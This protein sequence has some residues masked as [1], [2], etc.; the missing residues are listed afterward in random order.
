MSKATKWTPAQE[1]AIN[2]KGKTLLISAAA[3]SGK[4]ATLTRRIIKSITDKDS[5]ADISRL[6]VVTFTVAAASELKQRISLALSRE[7]ATDPSN[8]RLS[9]QLVMLESAKISTIDSFAFSVVK[10]NFQ[11]LSLP[12]GFKIG[13]TNELYLLHKEIIENIIEKHYGDVN[14]DADFISFVENFVDIK[15]SVSLSEILLDLYERLSSRAEGIDFALEASKQMLIEADGD[16]F[17]SLQGRIIS[18]HL[19]KMFSYYK[20]CFEKS[21]TFVE[22]IPEVLSVYGPKISRDIAFINDM[23]SALA[24]GCYESA[25]SI[26]LSYSKENI[27]NLAAEVQ[28]EDTV[29]ARE[30]RK[31]FMAKLSK[32]ASNHFSL[33]QEKIS[34][35]MKESA[36]ILNSIY[37]ILEEFERV[38][39][40]EK[41]RRGEFAFNDITRFAVKILSDSTGEPSDIARAYADKFDEI[42]IDEYQD[43][44]PIQDF[45]FRLISKPNN[46]FMVGDIKQSIYCFRNAEPDIFS[47]YK[48]SFPEITPDD[49]GDSG[50]SLCASIFMSENFRCDE[51]IIKFTNRVFSYIFS[52]CGKNINYTSNDDLKFSKKEE[53]R[54]MPSP[55]VNVRVIYHERKKKGEENPDASD[56]EGENKEAVWVANEIYRL[57]SEEKKADGTPIEPR[58]IAIILRTNT[59]APHFANALSALG[60]SSKGGEKKDIFNTPDVLFLISLLSAIDN[61][62]RDVS[63]A[64]TLY[65]PFFSFT[66]EDLVKIKRSSPHASSLFDS[67]RDYASSEECDGEIAEKRDRFLKKLNSYRNYSNSVPVDKLINFIYNDLSIL[68][69]N[70]VSSS[71]LLKLYEM[72]RTFESSSFKGLNNFI[73]YINSF[74]EREKSPDLFGKGIDDSN[75]VTITTIHYS[76]GLEFPVCFV[77]NC[78]SAF[79][80]KDL[81]KP[82]I[83]SSAAGIAFRLAHESGFA[84]VNTPLR[85]ATILKSK[86]LIKEEEMRLLY[87]AITRARERLYVTAR[88]PKN[89]SRSSVEA[90]AYDSD[91]FKGEYGVMSCENM[92]SWILGAIYPLE[93]SDFHTVEFINDD[94]IELV[95]SYYDDDSLYSSEECDEDIVSELRSRLDFQYPFEH[96]KSLPAKLSVSKLT[97]SVLDDVDEDSLSLESESDSRF[98]E[99]S[100]FFESRSKN[101][102]ADKGTATHLFLQFCDFENASQNGVDAELSRLVEKRFIS[103][104]V[105]EL[106]NKK[107]LEAFF[108][109]ELFALLSKAKR[110]YREQRFNILL[111][112]SNF[113]QRDDFEAEIKDETIL[114]QG[115]IDLF[116]ISEDGSLILC[117]YKTDYLTNEERS[118]ASLAKKKLK[119]RHG[120]QLSYYAMAIE[121]M[122]GKKPDKTLI[123]SLPFGDALEIQ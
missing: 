61:P 63:L 29:I 108:K 43:V 116:F 56:N 69:M 110:V 90:S 96:L 24:S 41:Y 76:K 68:S 42:Y 37:L 49:F 50:D 89:I 34:Q 102:A 66:M 40:A 88:I 16:F 112:A 92:L 119:D 86:E 47:S 44:S 105:S 100:E 59:Q 62:Q 65:S 26:I 22:A 118:D 77:S 120:E 58:D 84:K 94:G 87:V 23:L 64:A 6:L 80:Y 81:Q 52:Y 109:S 48:R 97:P 57:I 99:I 107:Q 25:R 18:E 8:K 2:T 85:E 33:S 115:V 78:A 104:S 103:K 38:S 106:I 95:N 15:D 121:Q 4:T 122:C 21:Y 75:S 3:G 30:K 82:I 17:A 55:A 28:T 117:D 54:S 9:K 10:E 74:I 1:L 93:D 45:L 46:R 71:N 51:N 20:D 32:A 7:I 60:I 91:Y 13:D 73:S 5:P 36:S 72:A 31:E 27:G 113:T 39:M 12:A 11:R 14:I 79:I 114:V 98:L 83:Y 35:T 111:P 101:T 53:G 67:L 19:V 123:Y 70:S